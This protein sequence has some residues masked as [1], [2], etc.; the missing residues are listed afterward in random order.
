MLMHREVREV[1]EENNKKPSL[2]LPFHPV[3]NHAD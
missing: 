1:K 3:K 2:S